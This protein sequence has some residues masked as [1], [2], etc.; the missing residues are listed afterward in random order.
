MTKALGWD[1]FIVHDPHYHHL[2]ARLYFS[3]GGKKGRQTWG[4][5]LSWW[6]GV[7]YIEHHHVRA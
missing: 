7:L 3:D 2:G 1:A 6:F 4:L 5:T